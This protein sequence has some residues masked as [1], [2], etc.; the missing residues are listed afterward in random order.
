MKLLMPGPEYVCQN[1]DC[2]PIIFSLKW[3]HLDIHDPSQLALNKVV[4]LA[5]AY[6][7]GPQ[8]SSLEGEVKQ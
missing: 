5:G 6:P 3:I 4:G 2:F 8:L 7:R 1:Q